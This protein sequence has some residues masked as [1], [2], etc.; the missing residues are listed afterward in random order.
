MYSHE[1]PL[2]NVHP[3]ARPSAR[4]A[5]GGTVRCLWGFCVSPV[6]Q[7]DVRGGPSG[8]PCQ[9]VVPVKCCQRGCCGA[10]WRLKACC[11]ALPAP[12]GRPQKRKFG[13]LKWRGCSR[14]YFRAFYRSS[15]THD[16]P[17]ENRRVCMRTRVCVQTRAW[18]QAGCACVCGATRIYEEPRPLKLISAGTCGLSWRAKTRV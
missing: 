18:T 9:A 8:Q 12:G 3:P 4:G 13:S 11:T 7:R 14:S 5:F 17:Y 2:C 1:C 6:C 15:A 10:P 16:I